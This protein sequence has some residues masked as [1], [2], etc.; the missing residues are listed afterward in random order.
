MP[1][2]GAQPVNIGSQPVNIPIQ[3]QYQNQ[4]QNYNPMTLFLNTPPIEKC[5]GLPYQNCV[6]TDQYHHICNHKTEF[7]I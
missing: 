3:Y 4:N 6:G 2:I 1:S 5:E 7:V